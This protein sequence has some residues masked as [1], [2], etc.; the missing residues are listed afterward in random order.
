MT[1][2]SAWKTLEESGYTAGAQTRTG[3]AFAQIVLRSGKPVGTIIYDTVHR[4]YA[5]SPNGDDV[6]PESII[7]AFKQ[8]LNTP[9]NFEASAGS[10]A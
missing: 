6:L 2:K 9:A 8:L 3:N 1:D 7:P 5:Y 10:T 4:R